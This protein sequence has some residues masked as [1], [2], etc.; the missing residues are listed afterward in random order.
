MGTKLAP[1]L[2]S[3]PTFLLPNLLGL[4]LSCSVREAASAPPLNLSLQHLARFHGPCLCVRTL[5]NCLYVVGVSGSRTGHLP[6]ARL[7]GFLPLNTHVWSLSVSPGKHVS[8]PT[9]SSSP[10]LSISACPSVSVSGSEGL[11]RP[12]RGGFT[13]RLRK[14]RLRG[15]SPAQDPGGPGIT[16]QPG[17]LIS[18]PST[19]KGLMQWS[20]DSLH[21]FS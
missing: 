10:S 9:P 16:G 6:A 8:V 3:P 5:H 21:A 4:S 2:C 15:P 14:L 13:A 18:A 12:P 7:C 17:C 19:G 20:L 11:Y 1:S